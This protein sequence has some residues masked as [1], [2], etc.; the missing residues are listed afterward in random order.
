[1]ASGKLMR[2]LALDEAKWSAIHIAD[3]HILFSPAPSARPE[4][5]LVHLVSQRVLRFESRHTSAI[6]TVRICANG[7]RAIRC[8]LPSTCMCASVA[9]LTASAPSRSG[10]YDNTVRVWDTATGLEVAVL[11]E[12]EG[13]VWAVDMH[14]RGALCLSSEEKGMVRLW[15]CEGDGKSAELRGHEHT[16]MVVRFDPAEPDKFAFSAV[17]VGSSLLLL[18][19]LLLRVTSHA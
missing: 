11:R 15:D 6:T 12:H 18:L 10:S 8:L 17:R 13:T 2:T 9:A 1:M 3:N 4:L 7:A 16:P 19:L 5:L 14:P